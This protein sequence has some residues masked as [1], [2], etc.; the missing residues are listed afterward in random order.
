MFVIRSGALFE[1]GT[2]EDKEGIHKE[3]KERTKYAWDN[4][5]RVEEGI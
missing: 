2:K 1:I 4:M 5:T 3:E